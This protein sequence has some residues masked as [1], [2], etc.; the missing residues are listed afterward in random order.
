M[1]LFSRSSMYWILCMFKN[2]LLK[3]IEGT[4][5]KQMK[6][7][8]VEAERPELNPLNPQQKERTNSSKLSSRYGGTCVPTRMYHV[9]T[10][11]E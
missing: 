6:V 10:I 5:K 11:I 2:N 4:G 1:V 8:D 3:N 7:S 9:H